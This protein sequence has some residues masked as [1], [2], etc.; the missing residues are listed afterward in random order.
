MRLV[1]DTRA[2]CHDQPSQNSPSAQGPAVGQDLV[3]TRHDDTSGEIWYFADQYSKRGR[4]CW[5]YGPYTAETSPHSVP[6]GPYTAADFAQDAER[7]WLA[8][9]DHILSRTDAAFDEYVDIDNNLAWL[10]KNHP[11]ANTIRV[12]FRSLQMLQKAADLATADP[13]DPPPLKRAWLESRF[14]RNPFGGNWYV[15]PQKFWNLYDAD[16]NS[17]QA[18]EIAWTAEQIPLPADECMSNCLLDAIMNQPQQYWK[19]LP[20]GPHLRD[21]LAL[22]TKMAMCRGPICLL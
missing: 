22:A 17:P 13:S 10:Q 11:D 14:D 19:R 2:L 16:P 15:S 7:D 3:T 18:E 20:A 1:V 9:L 12:R 21:A 5:I 6:S 4:A 8:V